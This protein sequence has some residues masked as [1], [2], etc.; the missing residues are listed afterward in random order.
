[1][2]YILIN[3]IISFFRK[4]KKLI[5]CFELLIILILLIQ[6]FI[7]IPININLFKN[8]VGL[9]SNINDGLFSILIFLLNL[10][11]HLIIIFQ[12]FDNDIKNG[13]DNIF[14][15]IKL[16]KWLLYK[17]VSIIL[18][19][20]IFRIIVY[21]IVTIIFL[22]FSKLPLYNN[23]FE[24]YFVNLVYIFFIDSIF[25][26]FYIILKKYPNFLGII[27]FLIILC[28]N[29]IFID[30]SILINNIY[31]F[32]MLTI[33]LSLIFFEIAK[34]RFLNILEIGGNYEN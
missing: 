14:L 34:S 22:V 15:R 17:F 12:I 26:N 10:G 27:L 33:A 11:F 20:F 4:Y 21:V 28:L 29:M 32:L 18:L 7:G 23:I 5:F 8:I 30:F 3:D 13:T 16:S 2:K 25:L 31:V 6:I 19:N 9:N 1:M 24:L